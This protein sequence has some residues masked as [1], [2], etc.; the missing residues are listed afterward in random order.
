MQDPIKETLEIADKYHEFFE[1][2]HFVML[3][4]GLAAIAL[5]TLT[6]ILH[7]VRLYAQST[8]KD[9]YD[10]VSIKQPR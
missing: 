2:W 5:T 8:L 3:V 4:I 1:A 6:Y 10:F 9:R 7:A